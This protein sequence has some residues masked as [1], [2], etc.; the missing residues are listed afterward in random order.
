MSDQNLGDRFLFAV[1]QRRR[2]AL[3][4]ALTAISASVPES[5]PGTQI[6]EHLSTRL[7][8]LAARYGNG[9]LIRKER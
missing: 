5:L 3:V 2:L 7:G 1:E 6:F 9:A 8:G 4:E